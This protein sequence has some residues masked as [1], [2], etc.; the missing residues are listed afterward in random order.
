M[1]PWHP[2]TET[3][4]EPGTVAAMHAHPYLVRLYRRPAP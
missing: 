2:H 3:P 4:A 1:T